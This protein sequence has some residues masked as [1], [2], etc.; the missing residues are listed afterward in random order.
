MFCVSLTIFKGMNA[1]ELLHYV[2]ISSFVSTTMQW[3]TVV[4]FSTQNKN[5]NKYSNK[6]D[7]IK[8]QF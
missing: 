7:A 1:P 6:H 5:V 4:D 8:L 2:H 3:Y